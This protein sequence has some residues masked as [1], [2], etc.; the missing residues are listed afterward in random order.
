MEAGAQGEG[1]NHELDGCVGKG[2]V[3]GEPGAREPGGKAGVLPGVE[4]RVGREYHER[5]HECANE[6]I[7]DKAT[8]QALDGSNRPG[9]E[10][11]RQ[12]EDDGA[13]NNDGNRPRRHAGN[14]GDDICLVLG[15]QGK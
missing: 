8:I 7:G 3:T 14:A 6:V 12:T 13:D 10:A 4:H 1:R 11:C 15:S 5:A 2:R 9:K